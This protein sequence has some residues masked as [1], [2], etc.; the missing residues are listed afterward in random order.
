MKTEELKRFFADR[1]Q[2][3]PH[4]FAKESGVSHSLLSKILYGTRGLTPRTWLK[5][6]PTMV[7]YG[8]KHVL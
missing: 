3:N 8:A 4:G 1:P 2:L 5:L 6:W 7:K